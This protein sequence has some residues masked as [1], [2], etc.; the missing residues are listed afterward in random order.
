MASISSIQGI[1]SGIQWQDMVDQLI[2]VD[3]SRELDPITRALTA[4]Q[5][6]S[7]AWTSYRNIAQAL[8][9]AATALRD[10]TAFGAATATGGTSATTGRALYSAT[11]ATGAQ[12]GQYQLEVLGLAQSEKI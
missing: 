12:P 7:G 1:A 2:A 3:S 11:A 9:D 6:K 4:N 8:A 10:S 5:T